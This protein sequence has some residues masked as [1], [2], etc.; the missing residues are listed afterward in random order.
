M[1]DFSLVAWKMLDAVLH[2]SIAIISVYTLHS[3]YMRPLSRWLI[4]LQFDCKPAATAKIE[5][6]FASQHRTATTTEI[7][8]GVKQKT[9][10]TV[11]KATQFRRR[12]APSRTIYWLFH[13]LIHQKT[14]WN[15]WRSQK[16]CTAIQGVWDQGSAT[17]WWRS[18]DTKINQVSPSRKN[19]NSLWNQLM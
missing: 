17:Q 12:S 5:A 18:D 1:T 9:T 3:T 8:R 15:L 10:L 6:T 11:K 16:N 14:M 7:A 13:P 19:Y 2:V 4:R